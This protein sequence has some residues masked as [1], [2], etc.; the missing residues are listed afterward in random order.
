MAYATGSIKINSKGRTFFNG[1]PLSSDMRHR[2]VDKYMQGKNNKSGTS[3]ELGISHCTVSRVIKRC[4]ET[5]RT[6]HVRS[7]NKAMS[8]PSKWSYRN[9]V[10]L[11]T[12]VEAAGTTWLGEIQS[13]LEAAGDCGR[14]SLYT[15]S[16]HFKNKLPS[17]R[18]YTRKR[19][20]KLAK[21]RF[22]D[23]VYTQLYI[24]YVS[25]KDPMKIKF[26]D[27]SGFRLPEAGLRHYGFSPEGVPCAEIQRLS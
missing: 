10:L 5:G 20:S 15:I 27:E 19:V 26:L 6:D 25:Q 8:N 7:E 2:I 16:R 17:N 12:I 14:V 11:E 24:D 4:N 13:K 1:K 23:M 18:R 22:T 9:S 3:R 21:E